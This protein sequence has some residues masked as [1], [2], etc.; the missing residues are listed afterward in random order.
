MTQTMARN[1]VQNMPMPD[2][3]QTNRAVARCNDARLR[4]DSSAVAKFNVADLEQTSLREEKV[5][6]RMKGSTQQG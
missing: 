4:A 2:L 3:E 6:E 1:K 5:K